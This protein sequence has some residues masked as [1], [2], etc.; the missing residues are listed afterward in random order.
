MNRRNPMHQTPQMGGNP[1]PNMGMGGQMG[2]NP[3]QMQ[4]MQQQQQQQQMA[5][6]AQ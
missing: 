4:M 3:Q 2:N 6:M 5:Q 1:A